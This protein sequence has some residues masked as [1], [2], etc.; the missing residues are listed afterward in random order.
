MSAVRPLL[1]Q[2]Q[3]KALSPDPPEAPRSIPFQPWSPL[4]LHTF[5]SS[6]QTSIYPTSCAHHVRQRPCEQQYQPSNAFGAKG[7]AQWPQRPHERHR[8]GSCPYWPVARRPHG[9][10]SHRPPDLG[11]SECVIRRLVAMSPHLAHLTVSTSS[12]AVRAALP[13]ARRCRR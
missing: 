13:A 5:S 2:K 11:Y 12:R 3:S 10:C 7:C 1:A 4:V 8:A 9:W 6:F